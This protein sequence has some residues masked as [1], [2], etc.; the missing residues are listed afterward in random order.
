MLILPAIDIRGGK[1]VRLTEGDY[2]REKVYGLDP[3]E[4]AA[5][6]QA[7]GAE[8][9]HMV[10]L[11]GAKAGRPVNLDV[12]RAVRA[13]VDLKIELGGGIR[14]LQV[15]EE[16]LEAG[17]NRVVVGTRLTQDEGAAKAFFEELGERVVA[18]ID[19]RNG[20][21]AVQGWTE[22]GDLD[23]IQFARR[24]EELGCKRVIFTDIARDGMLAGPNLEAMRA[25]ASALS[26]PVIASGGVARLDDL[27]AL[28]ET[29]VEGA[30]VGKALYEGRFSVSEAIASISQA[31]G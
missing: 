10:D 11:D 16:A 9:L 8:W 24:M 31:R 7:Q 13:A 18:G 5:S 27:P 19:T 30:I 4:V 17:V 29:G 25:M 15:A 22:T 12:V 23:G 1:C 3:A 20:R 26:I 28:A 14:T 6:F 2:G 21:V